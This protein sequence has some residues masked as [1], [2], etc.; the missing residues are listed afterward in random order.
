MI[1]QF[2]NEVAEIQR[3]GVA[4]E[5]SYR[6]ALQKLFNV[7]SDEV[8]AI[9]EP[10]R[11][12]VGAPDFVF[13]RGEIPI[14][15][16]EAKDLNV[17][18]KVMKGYAKDQRKRYTEGFPNL[19]YTNCLD[20]RFYRDGK[21]IAEITIADY[22]MGIQP[23]PERFDVLAQMLRDFIAQRPQTITS[24]KRLAERM[25]GKAIL[26][27]DVLA[28][29]L[30]QDK[31]N[32][33]ELTAQY[34][35]FKQH[36]I[37]DI[38]LEDFA[39]IY[40]E[41][42][43]YGMFA[44]R[45]HDDTLQDF[46]RQEALELL[47]QSNPFLRN[48]FGYI[49]GPNLDYRISWIIDDLAKVFQATDVAAIM[50]RFGNTTQRND[51]FLHFYEDFLAAYNPKKRDAR[52]V[53]YTPEP[54]VDFIVRAVDDVLKTE[55]AI[56]D[57]LADNR[58]VT[59]DWDTGQTDNKGKVLK[60]TKEVHKVQVLDPAV[61]TGTFL[62]QAIKHIAPRIQAQAG[63]MW[64]GYVEQDLIP[65]LHG[66]ELLMA[67]YAMCH[68]KLEMILREYGYTPT[69]NPP[70][71]SVYLTNSLEKG[72]AAY[73]RFDFAG[74]FTA[75]AKA[76]NTVKLDVPIMCVI[77]NP[78]YS[79]ISQNNNAWI[80][81]LI[82]P[83]KMEPGGVKK[84][85]ERKH[86]LNDDYVKFI[87]M[88]ESLIEKNGEGVLGFISNHGYISN[89][90]FRGMRWHLLKTFDKIYVLDLHGNSNKRERGP[91]GSADSNVF[92][93]KQ[94]VAIVIC[95]KTNKTIKAD[96]RRKGDDIP[97]AEVYHGE[98]WGK[99][100]DKYSALWNTNYDDYKNRIVPSAPYFMFY[101]INDA[102]LV[103]Y[104]NGFAI[105]DFFPKNQKGIITARDDFAVAIVKSELKER[106]RLFVDPSRSD[107]ETREHFFGHKKAD[108]Y[109]KGDSRGWKLPK[110]RVALRANFS[111]E[112]LAKITYRPFDTR[113]V[114]YTEDIIDWPRADFMRHFGR[115]GNFG[116][117]FNRGIE[118]DRPFC[119][120]FVF[121]E[122]IQHH[123]LSNKE[124]NNIAPLYLYPA[125]DELDQTRRVNFDDKLYAALRKK[126][127]H[128]KRG[129]ADE[130]A[131]FDYIYGVLHCPAYRETYAEFLKIDFPRIPWPATPDVF[132]DVSD[133][134]G[135]MRRLHLM[136]PDA[137]GETPF[138][139][140]GEGDNTVS[141]PDCRDGK[142]WI[143]GS[144][145]FDA[146]PP[147]SWRFC[148]GGYEPAQRWLKDRKGQTLN[149]DDVKHY[150][151]ILKILSETDRIMK[152]IDMPLTEAAD[153]PV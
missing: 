87:A 91:D 111:D 105:D 1:Q 33:T 93:I 144:Q 52:G 10:A 134:G 39:D 103:E 119:D 142:V 121:Q 77:G 130:V 53:W 110:A 21:I 7:L 153:A 65:R 54:V 48:L 73:Q 13:L 90:T 58:K 23:R 108:K 51:P 55:F 70:R 57:G 88:S 50:E 17:D 94:G 139:F 42:I 67:S 112:L 22:L 43:A 34:Q 86:W 104:D 3:T 126:A 15:H 145:F 19:I 25:A 124:A 20:W 136:E 148:I 4:R 101:P 131:V 118:E 40:A 123:S 128:P 62:A 113:W 56:P 133:K 97:L 74:W 63:G 146:V 27:K 38:S 71:V 64:A 29:S 59:I 18:L 95:I 8:H 135:Q 138:A 152:T 96:K 98:L 150:Q 115:I 12:E 69:A 2:L 30:A 122:M 78:P 99:R 49:A 147:E 89:P 76:A 125:E 28:R 35:A 82:A 32:E 47:P 83:Y 44:A 137:I 79:G 41:T 80:E 6:P 81:G 26:I 92:D 132:W 75:E 127:K 36:L 107:A 100:P 129:E 24:S 149:F 85:D 120:V 102:L 141:K 117:S 68:M 60:T 46:S 61:G 143:N 109:P 106:L 16:C 66:F 84:L 45:L 37:H 5:H 14:G 116:I 151:R 9:N 72:E 31:D 11:V 140:M 114:A